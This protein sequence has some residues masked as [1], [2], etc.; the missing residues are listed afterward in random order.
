[1][2]LISAALKMFK[3]HAGRYPTEE[4]GLKALIERPATYPENKRWTKIMDKLPL[5]PWGNPYQYVKS[6]DP[7]E[8]DMP[9]WTFDGH[10]LYSLGPDG[11]S[12]S[13]GCDDEDLNSWDESSMD[14]RPLGQRM[15]ESRHAPYA[16]AAILAL[17]LCI[18]T[19]LRGRKGATA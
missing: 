14:K 10:G 9:D 18:G 2:A 16:G 4:E 12:N 6:D 17:I 7:S 3:V 8:I 13:R 1:M 11:I 19:I 15:L 5:D